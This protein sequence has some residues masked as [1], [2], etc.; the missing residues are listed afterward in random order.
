[1]QIK[2]PKKLKI[3]I[4]KKENYT[5][6]KLLNS[7]GS[8]KKIFNT[9]KIQIL[10]K[11]NIIEIKDLNYKKRFFLL[12]TYKIIIKNLMINIFKLCKERLILEGVGYKVWKK[13]KKLKFK[14]GYSVPIFIKIPNGIQISIYKFRKIK[15]TSISLHYLRVFKQILRNLRF[16]DIYKKKGVRFY[17]EIIKLK[18]GKKN[19]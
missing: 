5:L 7:K 11:N 18:E 6:V 15:L 17:K 4:Y 9:K 10:K 19:R 12:L 14:L 1:M 13:K 2:I 8:I 16:P 3:L